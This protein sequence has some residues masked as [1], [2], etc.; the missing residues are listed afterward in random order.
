MKKIK[1]KR[2]S[3]KE[4]AIALLREGE[5]LNVR[6]REQGGWSQGWDYS[7]NFVYKQLGEKR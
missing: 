6:V 2:F 7:A 3:W 1:K 4:A 5:N